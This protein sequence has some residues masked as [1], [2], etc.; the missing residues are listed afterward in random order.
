MK[1][2]YDGAWYHAG[3]QMVLYKTETSQLLKKQQEN[4]KSLHIFSQSGI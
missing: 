1:S 2:F 3:L 4:Q